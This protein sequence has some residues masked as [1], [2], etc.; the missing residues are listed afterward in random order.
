MLVRTTSNF[1][2]IGLYVEF[3]QTNQSYLF[4][5]CR[6]GA[7]GGVL[8][9]DAGRRCSTGDGQFF[10]A[11]KPTNDQPVES[12]VC[13]IRQLALEAKTR[14]RQN[15]EARQQ[16]SNRSSVSNDIPA[17][18]PPPIPPKTDGFGRAEKSTLQETNGSWNELW[19]GGN[20]ASSIPPLSRT[21]IQETEI[22]GS[23]AATGFHRGSVSSSLNGGSIDSAFSSS[24]LSDVKS[25]DKEEEEEEAKKSM[26]L[27]TPGKAVSWSQCL[28]NLSHEISNLI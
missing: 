21:R 4:V 19:R 28:W 6:F 8:R 12:L 7:V 25:I 18:R 13:Q 3:H 24:R 1:V 17:A 22:N 2:G 9:V 11:C 15:Q 27:A 23:T 10:F 14:L 16:L 20:R 26:F 5:P